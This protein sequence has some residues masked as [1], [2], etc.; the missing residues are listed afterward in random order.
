MAK[1]RAEKKHQ[2][3]KKREQKKRQS[4]SVVQSQNQLEN[5]EFYYNEALWQIGSRK[6]D[7]AEKLLKKAAKADPGNRDILIELLRVG[8]LTDRK[9][10]MGDAVLQ[11]YEKNLL[12]NNPKDNNILLDLCIWL[13][14]LHKVDKAIEILKEIES[15]YARMILSD[16]KQYRKRINEIIEYA[17]YQA[18]K[19]TRQ[20]PQPG[21]KSAPGHRKAPITPHADPKT[22]KATAFS[23]KPPDADPDAN[24]PRI[25][26]KISPRNKDINIPSIPITL[27]VDAKEFAEALAS[28]RPAS[29]EEY[30]IALS[31]ISIRFKETFDHLLCLGTLHQITS[32]IYQEETA[33]KIL[34]TFRGRALLA[35]E[36]GMGKTIEACMIVKEYLMRQMIKTVLIMVPTP[37]VSQWQEELA[38]KFRLDFK[39]TDDAGFRSMGEAFWQEPMIVASINIAKSV[40]NFDFV[41]AREYDM[42]IVDEAHHLKNRSTQ[43]WKLVNALKKRF[44]LLLTATPVENNLMELYNLITLLKPGQ[45]STASAFKEEFMTRGDPTDPRNRVKLKE[46]LDQVMI[47]NTRAVANIAIPPRFAETIRI[48]PTNNENLLYQRVTALVNDLHQ[49]NGKRKRMQLKHLLAEAGS[50]PAAVEKTLTGML[51]D[52]DLTKKPAGPGPGRW[53]SDPFHGRYSQ[54]Q[55]H[56]QTDHGKSGKNHYFCQIPRHTGSPLR[57][58]GMA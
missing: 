49:S 50:S 58:A 23:S 46:L 39:S 17:T 45:L 2:K 35:D 12:K 36:V 25:N 9:E 27:Q 33:R 54:K 44:L 18:S 5:A 47:R 52:T 19:H 26:G 29:R 15:G 53:T 13:I 21:V 6:Y 56:A 32:L 40:K 57:S 42:V 43:N 11:L 55:R 24:M 10:L 28:A 30:E 31:A 3:Q 51:A 38:A 4:R 22:A 14:E 48:T 34:K 1:N 7:T 16:R 8:H 41:T 20:L 37:L